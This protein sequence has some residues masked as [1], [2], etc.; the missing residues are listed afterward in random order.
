MGAA[1]DAHFGIPKFLD[2]DGSI[3][4]G[5]NND[6]GSQSVSQGL[7]INENDLCG[8]PL[9]ETD[10]LLEGEI[11]TV[12]VVGLDLSMFDDEN[13]G[14]IWSTNSGAWAVLEGMVGPTEENIILVGQFTTTGE[15]CFDLNIQVGIPDSL[16][17][18]DPDCHVVIQFVAQVHPDEMISSV[19]TDNIF[20]HEDL[21]DC[22]QLNIINVE[23]NTINE[24]EMVLY[25]N[26]A[27]DIINIS[28]EEA[29][30]D[31]T[32]YELF[33][34]NGKLVMSKNLAVNSG[35]INESIDISGLSTGL[36]LL[37]VS[38]KEFVSSK[39][40]SKL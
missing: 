31:D 12:T 22:L 13:D 33:D 39:T 26:P 27:S 36:Y 3:V 16:V 9:T 28:I 4:G 35:Q 14:N 29:S 8:T 23:E 1:S 34:S 11:P 24:S 25:P 5:A 32:K 21:S 19:E 20:V 17:C 15:L 37:K 7:L 6:G 10:G 40:I 18:D 2:N 38:S 30:G